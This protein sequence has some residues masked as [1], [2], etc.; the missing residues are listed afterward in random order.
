MQGDRFAPT[1][2]ELL[3]KNGRGILSYPGS[4]VWSWWL[5]RRHNC[6]KNIQ[7][8]CQNQSWRFEKLVGWKYESHLGWWHSHILWKNKSHVWNHQPATTNECSQEP[9]VSLVAMFNSR[10][11]AKSLTVILQERSYGK[12]S[13]YRCFFPLKPPFI[14]DFPWLRSITRGYIMRIKCSE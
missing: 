14:M 8:F 13:I 3:P 5:K 2:M 1:F 12:L 11:A 7:I 9:W 10:T 4:M 6:R